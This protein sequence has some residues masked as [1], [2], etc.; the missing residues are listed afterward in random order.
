MVLYLPDEHCQCMERQGETTY[1]HEGCGLLLGRLG[2]R[3]VQ[4]TEVWAVDNVRED[5]RHSRYRIAPEDV[6]N[7]ERRAEAQ[8]LDLVGFFHS[9]PD[10]PPEPSEYDLDQASW[11]GFAYVIV[12]V[13][14]GQAVDV[15][16]W[17]LSPDRTRFDEM[18]L[19]AS[20]MPHKGGVRP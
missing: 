4:V 20:S 14:S 15:R 18:T 11:P 1:P 7:A 2:E 9:H 8:G 10:A 6:L 17:T 16:A 13:R 19:K 5:S 12:S 3:N